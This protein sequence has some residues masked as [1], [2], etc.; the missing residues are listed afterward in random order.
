V[1]VEALQVVSGRRLRVRV[2]QQ[3]E[4]VVL[5]RFETRAPD[6]SRMLQS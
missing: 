4:E 5:K 1:E 6:P 3:L 2:V